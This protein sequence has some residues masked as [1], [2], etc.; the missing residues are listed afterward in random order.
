MVIPVKVA[1]PLAVLVSIT[2]AL[3]TV[4]QDWRHVHIRSAALLVLSTVAG[5]PLGLFLLTWVPEAAIKATLASVIIAF[6]AYSLLGRRQLELGN[7]AYSW[8]FGFAAGILGG[9]YGMNGPRLAIYGTLRDWSPKQFRA[10]LQGYF[11]PASL[12]GMCGYGL[13]GLWTSQVNHFYLWSLPL[14]VPATL[15]GRKIND[16]LKPSRFQSAVHA[17]LI[18]VGLTLFCQAWTGL[19]VLVAPSL[20]PSPR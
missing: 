16:H 18:L 19:V 9:A 7:D 1:A 5:I 6:S 8:L 10:T 3:I 2:I 15:L 11:L 4:L 20:T 17:G 13:T 12:I 14:V